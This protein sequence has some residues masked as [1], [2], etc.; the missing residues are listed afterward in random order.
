M[1][2]SNR[3]EENLRP[4]GYQDRLLTELLNK[5]ELML[6]VNDLNLHQ[7]DM[8][9]RL[10]KESLTDALVGLSIHDRNRVDQIIAWM[11]GAGAFVE[12][13][14]GARQMVTEFYNEAA[15]RQ[16]EDDE[17]KQREDR[18]GHGQHS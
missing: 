17:R 10:Y 9:N 3:M 16:R 13:I 7:L 1:V 8:V 18:Y 6:A 11:Q 12:W 2:D 4:Q 15:E 14:K 5:P